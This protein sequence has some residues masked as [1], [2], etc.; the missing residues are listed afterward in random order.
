MPM[1]ASQSEPV[2]FRGSGQ[3]S[4]CQR[5]EITKRSGRYNA[6]IVLSIF[7]GLLVI[8][9]LLFFCSRDLCQLRGRRFEAAPCRSRVMALWLVLKKKWPR[10]EAGGQVREESVPLGTVGRWRAF[11][12]VGRQSLRFLSTVAEK[13]LAPKGNQ[14]R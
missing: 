1:M 9:A 2:H 8:L 7:V 6:S 10:V 3:T 13:P 4:L 12:T 5:M 11:V 14:K